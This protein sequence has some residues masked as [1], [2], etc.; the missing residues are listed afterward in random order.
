M[1]RKR[2]RYVGLEDQL[3][4]IMPIE[5]IDRS[6]LWRKAREE[7]QENIRDPKVAG[8]AKLIVSLTHPVLNLKNRA[9]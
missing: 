1:S 8:K 9:I 6:L 3:E 7:K 5:E 4:E 2:E